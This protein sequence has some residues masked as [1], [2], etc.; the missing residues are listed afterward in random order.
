[1]SAV[2]LV[3]IFAR[4]TALLQKFHAIELQNLPHTYRPSLGHTFVDYDLNS[5]GGQDRLRSLA[6]RIVEEIAE[7]RTAYAATPA[8]D[9]KAEVADAFHF[10][11]EFFIVVGL[12]PSDFEYDRTE[13]LVLADSI[14]CSGVF[15][16]PECEWMEVIR[17]LG[18]VINLLKNRPWKRSFHGVD[19]QR[20]RNEIRWLLQSFL[21]AAYSMGISAAELGDLYMG[22]AAVNAERIVDGV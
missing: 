6:W 14:H 18:M 12:V 20:F 19:C 16:T 3:E 9:Y 11:I 15:R 17:E 4:Q 7:L 2:A 8:Q 22:K 5:V 13:P 21:R 1:M 10:L